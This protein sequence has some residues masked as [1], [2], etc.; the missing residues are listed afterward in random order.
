MRE[1]QAYV[2][3]EDGHIQRRIDVACADDDAA[4][5]QAEALVDDHSIELWQSD[6]KIATFEPDPLKSEKAAGWI[7][8]ELQPPD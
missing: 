2:I 4:K 5:E 3:G 1:Y 7:K 8:S 6:R